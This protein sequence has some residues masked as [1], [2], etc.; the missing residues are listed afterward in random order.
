MKE[1][2]MYAVVGRSTIEDFDRF[3]AAARS[4]PA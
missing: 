2:R 1:A 3:V 4:E